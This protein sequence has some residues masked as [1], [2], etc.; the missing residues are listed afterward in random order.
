M[1][2][3][4]IGIKLRLVLVFLLFEICIITG[5]NYHQYHEQWRL[6]ESQ[7]VKNKYDISQQLEQVI[8]LS[9][10]GNN[11]A[12][13]YLPSFVSRLKATSGL[14]Y[15][16]ADGLSERMNKYQFAYHRDIGKTWRKHYPDGYI[17]LLNQK[18]NNLKDYL[19][20]SPQSN[21]VKIEYLLQRAIDEQKKYWINL[22]NQ[23]SMADFNYKL[24]SPDDYFIDEDELYLSVSILTSNKSGGEIAFVY[25]LSELK[26]LRDNIAQT[27]VI[28]SVLL[29]FITSLMVIVIA[30]WIITPIEK[31]T[32]YLSLDVAKVDIDNIPGL[33]SQDEVGD[34]ARGFRSLISNTY[35]YLEHIEN[36]S[37]RDPLTNLYNRRYFDE[38]IDNVS[39]RAKRN[40]SSLVFIYV[41]IDTF[42]K[43]NDN[44]GHDSGD[45]ALKKVAQ[46]F[47]E[48]ARRPDDH[49]FRFGGE[50]FLILS[51][52]DSP[53]KDLAFAESI[54]QK[55]ESLSI[56]HAYNEDCKNLT[57]SVGACSV[58]NMNK[59][60]KVK[61]AIRYADKELFRAKKSGRNKV[62]HCRFL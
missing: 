47:L 14:I 59:P 49:C 35:T 17:Q 13:I 40:H 57:V 30:Y 54:R 58:F 22:E 31:L 5:I 2:R 12:N 19:P 43:Y 16:E 20:E 1:T 9:I 4:H 7:A 56:E 52:N 34:L 39:A 6:I 3:I 8:A 60:F 21:A 24:G 55:V 10:E 23:N 11:Y 61:D 28:Q 27:L 51:I 37:A 50:E 41:D 38:I 46:A 48:V 53:E 32:K 18:I 36:L 42:K 33:A 25:D 29:L 26:S 44:Y 45:E 15:L 62:S